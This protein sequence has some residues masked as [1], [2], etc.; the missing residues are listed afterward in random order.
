MDE[1]RILVVDDEEEFRDACSLILSDKGYAVF[2]AS[3]GEEGLNA[4][5][6]DSFDLVLTD[7]KMG[8]INGLE[9]L[10]RIREEFYNCEVIVVTGYSTVESAVTAIKLGAF[11]YFIKGQDP[12]LLL[13]DIEKLV[14]IKSLE[15]DNNSIKYGLGNSEYLLSTNNDKFRNVLRIAE[16]SALSNSN[17]LI[18][19]ESGTGKE[20]I[21][22][23]IHQC[24]SRKEKNFIPVNCQVFSEGVLVSELFGHEKGAF[25]GALERRIGRFEEANNGTLFL[26]EIG[27]LP[28]ST[29][30]KLLR[31]IENKSIERIGSNKSIN[32]NIRLISATNRKL[33]EEIKEGRF[34]EDLFYRINTITL[35]IPPLRERKEDLPA[36]IEFFLGK[37]QREMKKEIAAVEEGLMKTLLEYDYPGNLRELRN[38][39]ERL[40]VL[41]EN[42]TIRERDLPELTSLLN[43]RNRLAAAKSLKDARRIAETDYISAKLKECNGNISEAARLMDI[44]RR[45]LFNK[46]QEYG[47][48]NK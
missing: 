36:M 15:K 6:N 43:E 38:I 24:S 46:M 13:K 21:A 19:G 42:S 29:Q 22:K 16:K 39:I 47:L 31:V 33:S 5:K 4:L 12:E 1:F 37:F 8:G 40:V 18:L 28:H 34:R 23:Y 41:S 32:V 27:E 20:V 17:I 30:T 3:S 9:F 48:K 11:G 35:E 45:Q 26:D 14:K 44:S 10:A 2:L 25:T 7:L